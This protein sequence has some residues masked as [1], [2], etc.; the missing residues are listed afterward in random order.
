MSDR[1]SLFAVGQRIGM[2]NVWVVCREV[3]VLRVETRAACEA[4]L[5]ATCGNPS[6]RGHA[7]SQ[8]DVICPVGFTAKMRVGNFGIRRAR[9]PS[10]RVLSANRKSV[11][12]LPADVG[13][14]VRSVRHATCL[15]DTNPTAAL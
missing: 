12:A 3:H 1:M 10:C 4:V 8:G 7:T 6:L 15:F 5:R 9:R 14:L 13:M 2:L 11:V